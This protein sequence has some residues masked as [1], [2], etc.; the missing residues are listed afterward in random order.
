MKKLWILALFLCTA[1]QVGV[2]GGPAA[3]KELEAPAPGQALGPAR[4]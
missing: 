2:G 3:V 4:S 1:C